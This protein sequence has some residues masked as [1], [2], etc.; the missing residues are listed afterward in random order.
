VVMFAHMHN[1]I[2]RCEIEKRIDTMFPIPV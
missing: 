2:T 1:A